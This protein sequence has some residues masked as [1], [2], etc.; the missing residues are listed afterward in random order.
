MRVLT[1]NTMIKVNKRVS[2]DFLGEEYKDSFLVLNSISVAQ[3]ET[4]KDSKDSVKD[5][6][7]KHFVSGRIHQEG[8]DVDI[9]KENIEE[10][11]GEVFVKSFAAITGQEI[12]PNLDS[13]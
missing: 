2:L 4:L 11:P 6:V 8:G 13:A 3:Y 5:T 12:A 7:K 1:T 9:T 10:L